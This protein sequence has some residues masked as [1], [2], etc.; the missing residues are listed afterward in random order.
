MPYLL[1]TDPCIAIMRSEPAVIAELSS[2]NPSDCAVSTVTVY[3]LFT[4]VEKCSDP[5]G[6]RAK[7]D[8]L[9]NAMTI[10]AFDRTAAE[11]AGRI[12]ATLESA[13]QPIGPY[14]T[15]IA[16]QARIRGLTLVTSNTGEFSR[17][18]GLPIENWR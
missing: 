3:E 16:A 13:G 10:I 2:R 17:V 8:T 15:L 4:G 6:E 14:D 5:A 7:V 11:E 18:A 1:D 12:R 9:L